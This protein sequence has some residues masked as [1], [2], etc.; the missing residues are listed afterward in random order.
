MTYLKRPPDQV[1]ASLSTS[2]GIRPLLEDEWRAVFREAG[3]G[4]VSSATY[5]ADLSEMILSHL[6]VDGVRRYLSALCQSISDPAIRGT[7]FN[8]GMLKAMFQYSSYVGYG[9]YVS[10]KG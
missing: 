4:D 6:Q 5:R 7:F 2:L 1:R 8:K 9:L 3:F 10:R